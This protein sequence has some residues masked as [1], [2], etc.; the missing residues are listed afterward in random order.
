MIIF[1]VG[2]HMLSQV[3]DAPGD[4]GNLD[5]GRTGVIILAGKFLYDLRFLGFVQFEYSLILKLC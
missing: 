4:Y 1:P 3:A 5:L 2:S